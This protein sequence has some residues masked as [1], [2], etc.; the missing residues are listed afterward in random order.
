MMP[1]DEVEQDR[2]S[3]SS[4]PFP[5]PSFLHHVQFQFQFPG[6]FVSVYVICVQ[7]EESKEQRVQNTNH[8]SQESN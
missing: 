4:S 3:K 8:K 6:V 1:N 7:R 5:I 2:L